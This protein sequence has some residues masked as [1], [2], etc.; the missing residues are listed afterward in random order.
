MTIGSI[1]AK[2]EGVP[3]DDRAK[4]P[5]VT[6]AQIVFLLIRLGGRS[7]SVTTSQMILFNLP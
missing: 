5:C 3:W 2:G 7:N 1:S 6:L 4:E